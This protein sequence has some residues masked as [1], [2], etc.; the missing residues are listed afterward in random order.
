MKNL[1]KSFFLFGLF[2]LIFSNEA[3]A[4][5][6]IVS[7]AYSANDTGNFSFGSIVIDRSTPV[8][9]VVATATN[10]DLGGR[11]YF[12][13]CSGDFI[14]QWA[15]GSGAYTPVSYGGETL[16]QS[17]VAGLAF[18]INTPGAGASAGKYGTAALPRSLSTT[19][20]NPTNA[21]NYTL[22][23]QDWGN[24]ILELVKIAETTGSG[25]LTT[26]SILQALIVGETNIMNYQVTAGSVQTNLSCSVVNSNIVVNLGKVKKAEFTGISTAAT[27]TTAFT[28]DLN[29]DP[30]TN[31]TMTIG[32]GTNGSPNAG[33]GLLFLDSTQSNKAAGVAVQV[34]Y[35]GTNVRIDIA[36][37]AGNAGAGGIYSIPMTA[38]YFQTATTVTVGQA[39]A[40]GTFT[41]T[42]Q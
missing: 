38:R 22:C 28:I 21:P 5:C 23:G 20:C 30:S 29:C 37:S 18:R 10:T 32:G 35:N 39:N 16:Y 19:A 31:V 11:G 27:T 12:V 24:P 34:L 4:S 14:N 2:L 36:Q 3:M 8:G 40:N 13:S 25:A 33:R 41:M 7:S 1:F 17:G 15:L 9:S 26:G 6:R 42:Y